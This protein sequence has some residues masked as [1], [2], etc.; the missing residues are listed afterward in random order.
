[1]DLAITEMDGNGGDLILAGNDLAMV[2]GIENMPYLAMFGGNPGFVTDNKVQE[3]E[4]FDWWGNN[5]L[6]NGD[7]SL[8]FNSLVEEKLRTVAL[9]SSGRVAIEEAVKKDLYF[10][11]DVATV[12]V[13]VLIIAI[14]TI[15]INIRIEQ[16]SGSTLIKI[17]EFRKTTDGDFRFSDFNDDFFV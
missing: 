17:V 12:T 4:S 5:L 1:M 11:K 8:Q 6:M 14:D 13:D 15:Q 10:L 2:F 3:A 16:N 9:N 7:Q